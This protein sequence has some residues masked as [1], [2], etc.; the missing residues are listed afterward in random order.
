MHHLDSHLSAPCARVVVQTSKQN[1]ISRTSSLD[2]GHSISA[3]QQPVVEGSTFASRSEDYRCSFGKN[4]NSIHSG[5]II[6]S[7]AIADRDPVKR[8]R[9][10]RN[11]FATEVVEL[12]GR[13]L[14]PLVL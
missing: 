12:S 13:K 4:S 2:K 3:R 11:G 1:A 7:S 9:W 6:L 8:L 10:E 5:Y 14:N